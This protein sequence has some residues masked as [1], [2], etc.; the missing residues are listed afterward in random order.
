MSL[1]LPHINAMIVAMLKIKDII[2]EIKDTVEWILAGCP[3]P[4]PIPIK[5][6]Y[7]G[8]KDQQRY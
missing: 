8:N 1:W 6:D 5:E 7:D 3:K 4:I 2:E